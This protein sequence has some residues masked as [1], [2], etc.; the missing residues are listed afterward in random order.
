MG[1]YHSSELAMIFGT[2]PNYRGPSTVLEYETSHAMQD[3]WVAFA[4]DPNAGLAS[5]HWSAYSQLGANQVREF[6][7]IV[8]AQDVSIASV[9]V[10]CGTLKGEIEMNLSFH[11]HAI[12]CNPFMYQLPPHSCL[13]LVSPLGSVFLCGYLSR[14]VDEVVAISC[15]LDEW[16]KYG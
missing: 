15:D 2:H 12:T 1:A 7:A 13:R 14:Q 11:P 9:E 8:A 16:Q 5:Q 4:T 6:G 10:Q 3:A